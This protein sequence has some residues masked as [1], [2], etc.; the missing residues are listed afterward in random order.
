MQIEMTA[1]ELGAA[2][3]LSKS[4]IE[5]R[6][7]KGGWPYRTQAVRGGK[8]RLY[9]V[10]ALPQEIQTALS[11]RSL[12]VAPVA[13]VPALPAT[14]DTTTLADWQRRSM[15][16]RAALLGEI[17]RAAALIG[18]TFRAAALQLVK[19]AEAGTLRADLMAMI[20][21][22]NARSGK[23]GGRL[24]SLRS[25]QRWNA[26]RQT[27]PGG[28]GVAA[29]APKEAVKNGVP[30]WAKALLIAWS[31]PSKKSLRQILE[32][33]ILALLPEHVAAPSY[34]QAKRFLSKLDKVELQRGRMGPR[35]LKALRPYIAR[36]TSE[37]LPLDVVVA[38]G[39]CIDKE[40]AHP[41]H[42]R[43]FRP[44]LTTVID[45][46]TRL[47]V[48]W[49]AALAES[50][51]ATTDAIIYMVTRWGIPAIWYCDNG[52]GYNN[53][54]M[55]ASVTGLFGRLGVT[56]ANRLPYNSQAG[57]IVERAHQTIWV[58]GA[59][60]AATYMGA[61]MDKEARQKVF[62]LVR[63]DQRLGMRSPLL[64]PWSEFVAWAQAQI[65]AY[66]AR[67]HRSLPKIDD[68]VTGRRR[69]MSPLEAWQAAIDGGWE[70]MRITDTE[71]ADLT[72]P[73]EQRTVRRGLVQ[74]LGQTYYHTELAAYH[75][76]EVLVGYDIHDASHVWV[77]TLEGRLIC[78]ADF[79]GNKRAYM[80]QSAVQL[81]A[82]RRAAGREQR[83]MT[84]L[85]E[86]RA[87]L[88]GSRVIDLRAEPVPLAPA[89]AAIHR[90]L[91]DA[92]AAVNDDTAANAP[93]IETPTDRWLRWCDLDAAIAAGTEVPDP[94]RQWWERYPLSAEWKGQRA[95]QTA[96][97]PAEAG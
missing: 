45:A 89:V 78:I 58:R 71:A 62:K 36:D 7:T 37:L 63:K 28:N 61:P 39:H 87:E 32:R 55:D 53:A 41:Q 16:A 81:A 25:L 43:P 5:R 27:A 34:D 26:E 46:A 11:S 92:S 65:D 12:T 67:P 72:R 96:F 75:G 85:D 94:D 77:R 24:V 2:L 50:S 79:E 90:Q 48:G 1:V 51:F 59:K 83:L 69:H 42:G 57:G 17:D 91:V 56:K 93:T 21:D 80:P 23:T 10:A 95:I 52:S 70:P 6:A 8:L 88:A 73:Y 15:D 9:S 74:V 29:L 35:E 82:E 84:H 44:E 47:A 68:P 3:G 4:Q 66:N 30:P 38:D 54:L 49:S 13:S 86:V 22:A 20:P 33:D 31:V 64:M 40:V 14:T 76:E 97:A 19:A 18:T 60:D